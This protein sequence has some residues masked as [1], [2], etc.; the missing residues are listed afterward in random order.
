MEE[1]PPPVLQIHLQ[2]LRGRI[3]QAVPLVTQMVLSRL[4]LSRDNRQEATFVKQTMV[5]LELS[6]KIHKLLYS[7]SEITI[8]NFSMYK[9]AFIMSALF[10]NGE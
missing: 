2:I 9:T 1:P 10:E 7:V 6:Q 3:H 8:G 4:I 5:L